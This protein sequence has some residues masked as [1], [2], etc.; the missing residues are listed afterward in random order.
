MSDADDLLGKADALLNRYRPGSAHPPAA[1]IPVLTDV[2][3]LDLP[4]TGLESF[5]ANRATPLPT[6]NLP[7]DN[8]HSMVARP[9]SAEIA[10]PLAAQATS[11]A[12]GGSAED[13]RRHVM[14]ALEPFLGEEFDL[15]LRAGLDLAVDRLAF[16]LLNEVRSELDTLV[17]LAVAKAL[18]GSGNAGNG[19]THSPDTPRNP[20]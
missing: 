1:D 17:R 6:G 8:A 9:N 20:L 10:S 12:A 19:A 18:T 2:V 3:E 11:P 13:V 4:A 5:H 16:D 7:E 14:A 15:R